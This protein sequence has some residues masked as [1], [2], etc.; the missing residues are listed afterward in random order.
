MAKSKRIE[1]NVFAK[2]EDIDRVKSWG[3]GLKLSEWARFDELA[4][5]LGTTRHKLA[6]YALRDFLRR[7]ER[8][9]LPIEQR[10]HLPDL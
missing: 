6:R 10:S 9:E 8:G 1:T 3:V 4:E 7:Y 5:E 2:T